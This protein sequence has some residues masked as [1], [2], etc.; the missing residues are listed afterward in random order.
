MAEYCW[1]MSEFGESGVPKSLN[2]S[3]GEVLNSKVS[4]TTREGY[5]Y[6]SG[7][8]NIMEIFVKVFLLTR[9]SNEKMFHI[10]ADHHFEFLS[11]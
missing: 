2:E 6:Q 1:F 10:F 3:L 9:Y 5:E 11:A 4:I 8:L 7:S